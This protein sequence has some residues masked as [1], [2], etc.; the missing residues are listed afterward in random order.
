MAIKIY[1]A[2]LE[3]EWVRATAPTPVKR[4]AYAFVKPDPN[5]TLLAIGRCPA[6]ND[7]L[8]NLYSLHSIYGYEFS[9]DENGHVSSKDFDQEFFNQHVLV[10]DLNNKF[11]SFTQNYVFFTDEPSLLMS[12]GGFPVFEDNNITDSCHPIPGVFDI[13]K[14]F[15]NIEFPFIIKKTSDTFKIEQGEVYSYLK[16]HTEED[17]EFIQFRPTHSLGDFIKVGRGYSLN[18]KERSFKMDMFY[19]AFTYKK[20][21]LKEIKQNL[22]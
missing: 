18:S 9:I 7:Y 21:I 11:F 6:F 3:D 4:S 8:T 16:F 1:W 2:C 15:R 12:T 10:R 17:I 19:K 13:G 20:L 14:W 5:N 22:I